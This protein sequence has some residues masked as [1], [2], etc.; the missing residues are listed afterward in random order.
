[1][2]FRVTDTVAGTQQI[3]DTSTTQKHPLGTIVRAKDPTYGEGEFIYLLGV[4]S[5]TV[6]AFV[7][8]NVATGH[9]TA[10]ATSAVGVPNPMAVAMSANVASAYGWYQISG[11]AIG[12]TAGAAS[13]AATAPFAVASGEMI[14]AATTNRLAGAVVAVANPSTTTLLTV[15]VLLDRPCGPASD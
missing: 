15:N 3:A 5:T 10:L 12:S 8:Y 14:A 1:M 6:G 7:T 9:Q 13:F 4:G 11:L 2:T